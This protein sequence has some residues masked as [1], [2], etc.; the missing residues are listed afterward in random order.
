MNLLRRLFPRRRPRIIDVTTFG[1]RRTWKEIQDTMR[2]IHGSTHYD[3]LG[4]LLTIQR[5]RCQEAVEMKSNLPNNA[6]T[7]EAG[8]A[9]AM[10]EMLDLYTSLAKGTCH[11]RELAS[12]FALPPQETKGE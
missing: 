11:D 3:V 9:A 4:Q 1:P 10:A 5:Q 12:W 8:A 7:F 2:A 6:T